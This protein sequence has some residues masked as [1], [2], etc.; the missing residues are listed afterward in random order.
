MRRHTAVFLLALMAPCLFPATGGAGAGE[1]VIDDFSNG[2]SEKWREKSFKGH[3]RYRVTT[4]YGAPCLLAESHGTASGLFYEIEF[5]P[6]ERPLLRWTW[7]VD[8]VVAGGD[9]RKKSGDDYAARVYVVF[10]GFFFWQ[11]RAL[12]YIWANT[13]P[14]G[15]VIENAYTSGAMM[16]AV[17]SGP[18]QSGKFITETRDL[19]ADYKT[20]FG[21]EPPMAG[22][23]AIMTDTDDTGGAA[24]ACYGP[25]VL[26]PPADGSMKFKVE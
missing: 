17:E 3:T 23:V 25:I 10:P 9:A 12:N 21:E 4:R 8:G 24:A 15:T 26:G 18:E 11:T 14:K 20:A 1:T 13:L 16:I 22:A 2:L 5:D 19:Y 6:R 7:R